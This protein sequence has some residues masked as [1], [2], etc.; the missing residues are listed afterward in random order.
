MTPLEYMK[1]PEGQAHFQRL[2]KEYWDEHHARA[3]QRIHDDLRPRWWHVPVLIA[4]PGSIVIGLVCVIERA[5][6]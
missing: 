6:L 4:V 2:F 1:S 5:L 3:M